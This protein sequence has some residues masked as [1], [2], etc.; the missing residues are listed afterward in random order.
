MPGKVQ[1]FA[2]GFGASVKQKREFEEVEEFMAICPA[3]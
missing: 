3:A 1:G 2:L